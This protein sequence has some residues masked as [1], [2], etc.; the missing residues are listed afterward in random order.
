MV[1]RAPLNVQPVSPLSL[2]E[3]W[4]LIIRIILPVIEAESPAPGI[5]DASG[6]AVGGWILA[7]GSVLLWPTATNSQ[8]GG[9]QWVQD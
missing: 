8:L 2:N 5:A 3:D 6:L 4:N 1:Q 9:E 7:A